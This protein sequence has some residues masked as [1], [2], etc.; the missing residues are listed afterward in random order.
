MGMQHVLVMNTKGG[1]GKSTMSTNLAS[2]YAQAG[3]KVQLI[4][5][6]PQASSSAWLKERSPARKPIKGM[7]GWQGSGRAAKDVDVAIIDSPAGALGRE[8]G[9]L[10]RYADSII[11]PVLPSPMDMRASNEFIK[12]VKDTNRVVHGHAQIGLVA[13]KVRE[14]TNIYVELR[15]Y[16]NQFDVPVIGHL[17]ESMNYVRAA[18]RG[19]GVFEL[20]PSATKKDRDQWKPIIDWINNNKHKEKKSS[21][22]T[23]NNPFAHRRNHRL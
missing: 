21:P 6:D 18:E 22:P 23:R 4:D 16:L 1:C 20:M 12:K 19:L 2:Y 7:S 3:K 13:N 14:N 8:I 10:L 5:Y 9:E 17:R 15:E 11:I